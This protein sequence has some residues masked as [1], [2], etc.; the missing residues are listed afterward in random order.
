MKLADIKGLSN[1]EIVKKKREIKLELFQARMKN[2][3][4]QMTNP[5]SIRQ[6]RRDVARLNT[7]MTMNSKSSGANS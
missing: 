6:M 7:V 3:M 1:A 5:I 4:G 2:A